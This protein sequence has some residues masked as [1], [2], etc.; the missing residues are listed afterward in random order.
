MESH[1]ADAPQSASPH[2]SEDTLEKYFLR[3]LTEPEY[4]QVET[5]LMIC[6]ACQDQADRVDAYVKAM[7]SAL[8]E[9]AA[10]LPVPPRNW[11]PLF[12]S[13]LAVLA[14]AAG[15]A[16]YRGPASEPVAVTL[17]AE[18]GGA[19]QGPANAPLILNLQSESFTPSA[20]QA[21][22]IVDAR[23]NAVWN[24][25]G[26]PSI[27]V[28]KPLGAGLFWV[29]VYGADEQLLREYGLRLE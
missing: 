2:V 25:T 13:G 3:Q 10:P 26:A 27:Q 5:H 6:R 19:A 29:R 7:K 12:A 11:L 1:S 8:A 17:R 22:R 15:V 28:D 20:S 24:G 21:V 16:Y 18:R 14:L 23:G 4:D 9:P